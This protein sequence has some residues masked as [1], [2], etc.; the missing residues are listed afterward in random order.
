MNAVKFL[1]SG[2]LVKNAKM[3]D[4]EKGDDFSYVEIRI[5]LTLSDKIKI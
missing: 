4:S 1:M 5:I 3:S 2:H